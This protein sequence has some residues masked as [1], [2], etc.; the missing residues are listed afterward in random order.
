MADRF[1]SIFR[2]CP[3]FDF[4]KI[5]VLIRQKMW[6]IFDHNFEFL[7]NISIFDQNFDF[8]QKVEFWLIVSKCDV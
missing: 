3:N 5:D 4:V 1:S 2:F 8:D 7:I 6:M